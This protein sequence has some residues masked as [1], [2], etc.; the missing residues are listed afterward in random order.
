MPHVSV[1]K[2]KTSAEY[3]WDDRLSDPI[4]FSSS[5]PEARDKNNSRVTILDVLDDLLEAFMAPG[6]S[7]SLSQ[8]TVTGNGKVALSERTANLL[9]GLDTKLSKAGS[10]SRGYVASKKR[11]DTSTCLGGYFQL[12]AYRQGSK[13]EY[14]TFKADRRYK[15][16]Q[17][18]RTSCW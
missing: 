17:S 15:R 2:S 13:Q 16:G 12:F 7:F 10:K 4:G 6:D 1:T 9:A 11:T 14:Q 8:P 18:R 3:Q 5:A